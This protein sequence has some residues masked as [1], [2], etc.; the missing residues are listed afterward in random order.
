[1]AFE[2]QRRERRPRLYVE[3]KGE[4]ILSTR[5]GP[6]HL[7]AR[8]DR[9]EVRD[10]GIDILDFKTGQLP[11]AKAVSAGFY[12]QLTLTAAMVRDGGFAGLPERP[13][14][15]LLYVQVTP[16]GARVRQAQKKDLSS[17]AAA[18][19]ALISLQQRLDRFADERT[20]YLSWA[21]PQYMVQRGGDYDQLARLYEWHVLG[22]EEVL[23]DT[24]DS[25][26]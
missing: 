10:D 4:L 21:A 5:A 20:G 2:A 8:A 24:E 15:D 18:N 17:E 14:G 7:T 16:D 1:V 25:D 22:E 3:Q 9:I 11:S 12:P 6:F 26:V 13:V 19:A 23:P